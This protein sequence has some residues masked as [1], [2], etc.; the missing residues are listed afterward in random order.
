MSVVK[1]YGQYHF[2][3][4]AEEVLNGS[5]IIVGTP[6][7]LLHFLEEGL[8]DPSRLKVFVLD[9]A[10]RLLEDS[11]HVLIKKMHEVPRFPSVSLHVFVTHFF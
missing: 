5:D 3:E 11:F 2:K 6:G 9:E 1:C 8:I 10:D 7:R 4:N